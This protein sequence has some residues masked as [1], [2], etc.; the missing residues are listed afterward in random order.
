MWE[1][2]EIGARHVALLADLCSS[3]G[4][5]AFEETMRTRVVTWLLLGLLCMMGGAL[6]FAATELWVARREAHRALPQVEPVSPRADLS[7]A[8]KTT[9]EIFRRTAPAVVHITTLE[10]RRDFFRRNV[11]TIPSGTGSGFIWDHAG[12][13]VTNYHVVRGANAVRVTLS[14]QSVWSATAVGHYA[15]K[16]IAVLRVEAPKERLVPVSAGKSQ[17]LVV[18]QHVFA[19]GNPFG[20]DHTLSTG[21][22]SGLGREILSVSKRPIQGVVQTDAAINPGNSGGPLLDSSGRLI[23]INTAIFSPSGASAGVGFAV[24]V[25][26][27]SRVVPQ[28][29]RNG[30]VVQPGLGVELDED[31]TITSRVG[32]RGALIV[33][34]SPGGSAE[35]AGLQ[36]TSWDWGRRGLILGDII[37]KVD[38]QPVDDAVDFFRALDNR[39]VGEKVLLTIVRSGKER[40]VEVMLSAEEG[41]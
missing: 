21:V 40:R 41:E 32:I 38:D 39:K 1:L 14:D 26:A 16:D 25:D 19:I 3:W 30:K 33:K 37:I 5:D 34:V 17:H 8:E 11:M 2:D 31:G 20:L 12:H 18:G 28:L 15:A 29:I 35:K 36:G 7:S 10:L 6:A 24:P 9:I 4:S 13:V 27:V 23:G 22:I